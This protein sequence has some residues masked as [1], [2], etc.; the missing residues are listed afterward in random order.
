MKTVA[1]PYAG[2]PVVEQATSNLGSVARNTIRCESLQGP[3]TPPE[4]DGFM[5]IL[6]LDE[7]ATTNRVL[8]IC[9]V[10]CLHIRGRGQIR[11]AA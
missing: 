1:E 4:V 10:F 6:T 5:A 2:L 7:K 8:D 3:A 9:Q 11:L